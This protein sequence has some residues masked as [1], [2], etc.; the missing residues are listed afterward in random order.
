MQLHLQ[1]VN[2]KTMHVTSPSRQVAAHKTTHMHN[3]GT[4]QQ[5]IQKHVKSRPNVM[6]LPVTQL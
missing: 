4:I 6:P 1:L 2:R 3:E 5:A